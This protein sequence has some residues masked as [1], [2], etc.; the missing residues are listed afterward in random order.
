MI[1]HIFRVPPYLNSTTPLCD[2]KDYDLFAEENVVPQML[3]DLPETEVH[4]NAKLGLAHESLW[5]SE[6]AQNLWSVES[7]E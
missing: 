4:S 2:R 5:F 7:R 6:C 3:S 1:G